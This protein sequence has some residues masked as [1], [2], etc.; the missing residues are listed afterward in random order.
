MTREDDISATDLLISVHPA[1]VAAIRAERKSVELRR[2]RPAIARGARLVF[3]ETAPTSAIVG[4]ATV[5]RVHEG[6]PTR[7]WKSIGRRSACSRADFF[8]YYADRPIAFAI[9]FAPFVALTSTASRRLLARRLGAFH[10]PQSYRY[11]QPDRPDDLRLLRLIGLSA[12]TA[13]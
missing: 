13:P 12:R 4:W 6:P 10:P 11:L 1:H 2:V 5:R 7:L 3:Y 9:E 8:E